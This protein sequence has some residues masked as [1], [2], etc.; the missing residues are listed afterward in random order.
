MY[1]NVRVLNENMVQALA[2]IMLAINSSNL[3]KKLGRIFYEPAEDVTEVIQ[4][5][6]FKVEALS[7]TLWL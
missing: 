2:L 6:I 4:L 7:F 5:F 3:I 1:A